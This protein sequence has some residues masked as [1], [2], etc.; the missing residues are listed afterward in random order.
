MRRPSGAAL[1]RD[2]QR[3][4]GAD[5]ALA[6]PRAAIERFLERLYDAAKDEDPGALVTYVN[7]PTTEYLAAAVPRPRLLQRLPR[8]ARARSS[9]YLARLQNL[10]GDRPL[11]M[12]ELGLD[13]RAQRRGRAGRA[14]STGSSAPPSRPAAPARSSSPGPTSGTAAATTSTTGTSA[15]PTATAAPKP[16]L[17]AV[18]R[19]LRR[20]AV[21]APTRDWPRDLGRRLHA[22]TA[23]ARIRETPRGAARL[24]YPDYEVIVVDDG[25]TD[26]TAGDRRASTRV[27]PDQHRR[28]AACRRA[29][30]T[31]LAGGDRRDRRL[32]RRRRL[33]RSALAHATS[34]HALHDAA[35][36]PA[37]AGRTSRRP[38]DGAVADCVA[39]RARR[40]DPRAAHRHRGRAHPRLQHGVPAASALRGDRRLRPAVPHRRRRRR[41]LLAAAGARLDASASA[42][43]RWSGTTAAT[44]SRAYWRQQRGYGKAEAL[45]ER[46]WPE[47]YNRAGHLALGRAALRQRGSPRALVAAA[48][49]IYHGTWG[50]APFQ[51]LY[52]RAAR[53]ARAS[54][55]L[56]PEWY[57]VIAAL[58]GSSRPRR[59]C[60]PRSLAALPLLRSRRAPPVAA[61]GRER[62]PR[63]L[64]RSRRSRRRQLACA[65]TAVLHLLQP[66]AR[67]R[68]RLRRGST[69][70]RRQAPAGFALPR[71]RPRGGV[72]RASGDRPSDTAG[73]A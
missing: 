1:L 58:A 63:P 21:P 16:A 15:S 45:L 31:G 36:T 51:S 49:R 61:G 46:K 17:A 71:A 72:E 57:L 62:R 14:S 50:S 13:S 73:A 29:R 52:E 54:L 22:T 43:R 47:Q 7:Y 60:G 9:A 32:H 64:P 48:A 25:S 65:P 8:V 4:P 23:R 69:P 34:P 39:Q 28:T 68:G 11:L 12:A 70:W 40:P 19:R 24:D 66:L 55:P 53:H 37:S 10:A 44:R 35:T 33:P 30:N 6:R 59:C 42:R 56:M 41:R 26:A 67:L 18:A 3:D 5:R 38:D 2:R 20:G 27:P